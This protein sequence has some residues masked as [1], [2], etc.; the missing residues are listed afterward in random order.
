MQV[1]QLMKVRN[2][3]FLFCAGTV[4]AETA[5][6]LKVTTPHALPVP[7][8]VASPAETADLPEIVDATTSADLTFSPSDGTEIFKK[9]FDLL[10]AEEA[11]IRARPET[12]ETEKSDKEKALKLIT[13][14]RKEVVESVLKIKK[15]QKSQNL[16]VSAYN[17]CFFGAEVGLRRIKGVTL[18]PKI[19]F[20]LTFGTRSD[21]LNPK[22]PTKVVAAMTVFAGAT[23]ELKKPGKPEV[24]AGGGVFFIN[25]QEQPK[26]KLKDLQGAFYG[27][28][29]TI[30]LPTMTTTSK[31]SGTLFVSRKKRVGS[32][33]EAVPFV[34]SDVVYWEFGGAVSESLI[35]YAQTDIVY[36]LHVRDIP[37]PSF[38]GGADDVDTE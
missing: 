25:S 2:L 7:N 22:N 6:N 9:V 26:M 4:Y 34:P 29:G 20:C 24:S 8:R 36:F 1:V 18:G 31:N 17:L 33:V 35:P 21:P 10:D 12:T 28:E 37:I 30:P 38:L 32:L 15:I 27:W 16:L 13:D 23:A 3:V 19:R 11:D 14:K 5:A